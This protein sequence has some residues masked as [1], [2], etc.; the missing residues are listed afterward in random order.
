MICISNTSSSVSF[1]ADLHL[2]FWMRRSCPRASAFAEGDLVPAVAV[3]ADG[4]VFEDAVRAHGHGE[5]FQL[6]LI[7]VVGA[8]DP[9]AARLVR[10][11]DEQVE[12]SSTVS[13]SW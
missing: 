1:C 11:G 4:D 5:A 6:G 12:G 7:L 3:G 10:V 9:V 2:A 8:F 13:L